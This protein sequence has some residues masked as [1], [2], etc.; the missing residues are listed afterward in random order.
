MGDEELTVLGSVDSKADD[1]NVQ[2]LVDETAG[3]KGETQRWRQRQRHGALQKGQTVNM[4]EISVPE[5][6]Q[7]MHDSTAFGA[8]QGGR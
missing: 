8:V 5:C 6:T 1:T 2:Q 7:P 4:P 3:M